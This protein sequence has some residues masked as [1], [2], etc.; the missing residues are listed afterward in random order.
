MT[1]RP[2]HIAD[3]LANITGLMKAKGMWENTLM[4]LS[5]DNVSHA[6]P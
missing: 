4:V 3:N 5:S 2:E 1:D 6:P